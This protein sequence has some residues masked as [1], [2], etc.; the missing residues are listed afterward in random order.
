MNCKDNVK[1]FTMKSQMN[2][3]KAAIYV[4]TKLLNSQERG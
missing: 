1:I 3:S 2:M 4:L